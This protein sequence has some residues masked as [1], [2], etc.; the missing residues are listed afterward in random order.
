MVLVNTCPSQ[1]DSL[2]FEP[3]D[4]HKPFCVVTRGSSSS[5]NPETCRSVHLAS[6]KFPIGVNAC[7]S[8]CVSNAED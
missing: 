5:D 3:S 2:G 4:Q 6:Q 8:I 7:L 1:Q